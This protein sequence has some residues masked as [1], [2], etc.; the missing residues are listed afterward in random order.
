MPEAV[1]QE[2]LHLNQRLLDSIARAD[3]TTYEEL[4]DPSLTAFEPESQGQFVEG[5]PFHRFYF[6]LGGV[7]GEHNT[8]MA[9][10]HVRVMGDVAVIAYVRLNQRV[11]GQGAALVKAVQET[12]VWQRQGD[13]WRHVHF[14]RSP[15]P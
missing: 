1:T 7:K 3:W 2:L 15:L 9:S 4:C 11:D 8:T 12:R 14:H 13:R 6:N 10:P 5:M